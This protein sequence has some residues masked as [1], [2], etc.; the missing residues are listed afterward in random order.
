MKGWIETCRSIVS[1][2]ECDTTEHFTIAYYFDRL[3]DASAAL[4]GSL[5]WYDA[6]R[7]PRRFDV[8]LMRELR[9]GAS[10]HI[11]SAPITLDRGVV[12][13]GHQIVDSANHEVTAWMEE[14]LEID[15]VGMPSE[16]RDAIGRRLVTW[17]GPVVERRPEPVATQGFIVTVRD[18]VKPPDLDG[19]GT[20]ALAA[21]V[22]RFTAACI[23][24]LAAIGATADY[25]HRERRGYSTFELALQLS[26]LPRLGSPVQVETGIAH[27]GNSSIRFLHRML[28]PANG[29]EFAR[30]SQ[31]GVQLDLEARRPA[32]LPEPL[33]EAAS[34]FVVS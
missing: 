32:A 5:K 8:R 11:L 12:R 14:T 26:G 22:H 3:S 15:A 33:R 34:R 20:F 1:P 25:M 31:F 17:A 6:P 30:L 16:V 4:S 27:L 9:A 18:R 13:L 24:A 28:D 10:F 7:I 2:W 23:Q 29:G 21:F 19:D